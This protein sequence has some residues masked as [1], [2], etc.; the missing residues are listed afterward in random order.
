MGNNKR[1]KTQRFLPRVIRSRLG[2]NISALY[3]VQ[4]LNYVLPLL[5]LPYLLRVLGPQSYG[6]IIFTQ[7]LARYAVI[8]TDFGFTLTATRAISIS[9]ES[10]KELAKIFWST[11]AAKGV[12]L[13]AS[14]VIIIPTIIA[15]PALKAQW[16]TAA[17]SCLLVVGSVA[18]PE[19]YFLGLERMRAIAIIYFVTGLSAFAAVFAFV[20]SDKDQFLAAAILSGQQLVAAVISVA[21]IP[22]IAPIRTYCPSARDVAASLRSSWHLFLCSAAGS[23]YLNS[24]VFFL[25]LFA[26]SYAVA[27][28]SLA[29]KIVLAVFNM[30]VPLIRA[31]YPRASLL[32]ARSRETA[33]RLA[34]KFLKITIPIGVL[35][36]L[37]IWMYGREAVVILGGNK[38][39]AAIPILRIMC[40]LPLLLAVASV[41]SQIVMINV[42][43]TKSLSRIYI[44]VGC[45]NLILL[46]ALVTWRGAAGAA[47]ALVTAEFIGPVLMLYVIHRSGILS[48]LLFQR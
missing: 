39:L 30:F 2:G 29:N 22:L 19:W 10:E 17:A 6:I 44:L 4:G 11:L 45:I 9:R 23:L 48:N 12:L 26:G 3:A 42:G 25:G 46:P 8:V 24:N 16:P 5:M 21:M 40:V 43:L 31:V 47:V 20:H 34:R 41:I 38:Y 1:V 32:F 28:Y 13:L 35:L 36:S 7:S 37:C 15:I 33:F 14:I 18:F 27:L